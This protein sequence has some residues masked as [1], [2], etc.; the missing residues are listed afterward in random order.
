[1]TRVG[2]RDL[3]KDRDERENATLNAFLR[4]WRRANLS[5]SSSSSSTAREPSSRR[6]AGKT[7]RYPKCRLA[8]LRAGMRCEPAITATRCHPEEGNFISKVHCYARDARTRRRKEGERERKSKE[9]NC[10]LAIRRSPAP[11]HRR[12]CGHLSCRE[13]RRDT[14]RDA[15]SDHV[16]AAKLFSCH[17]RR[18]RSI[19][20]ERRNPYTRKRNAQNC[21]PP[22]GTCR[23][24]A[25]RSC[26]FRPTV[27][28]LSLVL[29]R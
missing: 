27:R 11:R 12:T 10:I 6:G 14:T 23:R 22:T 15:S 18:R 25:R 4:A 24:N 16:L 21:V 20:S 3:L 9:E 26:D 5:S 8:G 1:M 13:T 29:I 2:A 19:A 17:F 28:E 7:D